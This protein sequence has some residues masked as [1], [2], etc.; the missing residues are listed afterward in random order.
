MCSVYASQMSPFIGRI[1]RILSGSHMNTVSLVFL[2]FDGIL[3]LVPA[4]N[5]KC[6]ASSDMPLRLKITYSDD[7][8]LFHV[9]ILHVFVDWTCQ[10][11]H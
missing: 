6:L 3:R 1:E 9:R 11:V 8:C 10:N 5:M 4:T 2:P 7:K